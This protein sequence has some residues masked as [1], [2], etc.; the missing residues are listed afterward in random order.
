MEDSGYEYR[1]RLQCAFDS[2]YQAEWLILNQQGVFTPGRHLKCGR[3]M[4]TIMVKAC[5]VV[6]GH[7]FLNEVLA[8]AGLY[9]HGA[10]QVRGSV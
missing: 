4:V 3:W 7:G 1:D 8:K 6:H 5:G 10:Q 9:E 2:Q